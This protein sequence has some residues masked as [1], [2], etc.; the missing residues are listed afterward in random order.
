MGRCM[1]R[2]KW[3][4]VWY[5]KSS[6]H[7]CPKLW[8]GC[9]HSPKHIHEVITWSSLPTV[10][11]GVS[12]YIERP[13]HAAARPHPRPSLLGNGGRPSHPMQ[14]PISLC[15]ETCFFSKAGDTMDPHSFNS[16][17]VCVL[18]SMPPA[19]L[20]F[21]WS[22]WIFCFAFLGFTDFW[23]L[24]CPLGICLPFGVFLFCVPPP[25]LHL[26]LW[27]IAQ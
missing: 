27:K 13:T 3:Q 14:H 15:S 10:F 18:S 1:E 19:P 12:I 17:C 22:L 23:L 25:F 21:S 7:G 26:C 5:F 24:A 6:Q 8:R 2:K 11:E 20:L 4:H 9:W 16:M